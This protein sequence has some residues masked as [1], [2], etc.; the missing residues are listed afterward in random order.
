[1]ND[2]T[3]STCVAPRYP[4]DMNEPDITPPPLSTWLRFRRYLRQLVGRILIYLA[5]YL[6]ISIL[7]IGPCFWYWFEAMYVNGP[8]WIVKFYAPLLW[9]CDR[10]SPLSWL[11]NTYVN[12]WIL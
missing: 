9:L 12:W 2:Q 7:T 5:V 4:A 10:F 8:R 6:G 11:V 1:M 3:V